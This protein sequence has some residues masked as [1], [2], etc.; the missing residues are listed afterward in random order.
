MPGFSICLNIIK[1]NIVIVT[2]VY[3]IR[4]LLSSICTSKRSATT[5]SFFNTSQNT[6]ITKANKL[7]I[8]IFPDYSEVRAFEVFKYIDSCVFKCKA[9]KIKLVSNIKNGFLS[10]NVFIMD[11]FIKRFSY[12]S[13][14]VKFL[15]VPLQGEHFQEVFYIFRQVWSKPITEILAP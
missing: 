7:L 5:L 11:H 12:L 9:T 3:Y 13:F 15:Y 10:N 4:I 8:N 1:N 14:F 2:N 6:R